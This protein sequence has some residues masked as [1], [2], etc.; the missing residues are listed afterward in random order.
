M[1]EG[2]F[3][4]DQSAHSNLFVSEYQRQAPTHLLLREQPRDDRNT[5]IDLMSHQ[6]QGQGGS[7]GGGS[8]EE[9]VDQWARSKE[10]FKWVAMIL[11]T[12]ALTSQKGGGTGIAIV[13]P[14]KRG[15]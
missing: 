15:V 7:E 2:G 8:G 6:G 4:F 12:G 11:R 5:R 13:C 9:K 14:V 1:Q 3:W 10:L